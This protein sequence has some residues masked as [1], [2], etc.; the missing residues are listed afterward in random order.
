LERAADT[1][2]WLA[3]Q[4]I[5]PDD[6]EAGIRDRLLAQNLAKSLLTKKSKSYLLKISLISTK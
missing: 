2:A 4:M 3:D 1:L 5:S 6:W